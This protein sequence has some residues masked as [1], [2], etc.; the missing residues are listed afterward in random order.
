MKTII[1]GSRDASWEVTLRAIN[2]CL[3]TITGVV[4][5]GAR[6]ADTHG[7]CWAYQQEPPIPVERFLP[8]WEG[9]GKGA[10]FIR[11]HEMAA[12]AE[13]LVLVWDGVSPGSKHMLGAAL[14]AGLRTHVLYYHPAK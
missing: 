10:G 5:G 11:N 14:G 12:N 2:S 4:S 1:A 13:A 9:K 8:D 7:E 3:W 6:G